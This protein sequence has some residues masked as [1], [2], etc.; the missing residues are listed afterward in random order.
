MKSV[1]L[2]GLCRFG[3][4]MAQ[5]LQE[6]HHEVLAVD[7]EEQR[8]ND[9]LPYVTNAQIGDA[10]NE[11]FIASLGVRNFD[12]CVVAIG[13]DFQSSLEATALLKE[14]G[15][16]FVV[17]RAARDVHAKFLLRNG[18]DDVIY[19]ER[20]MASWAAVRYSSGHIFDYVELTPEY[21]IFET[22]VPESWVGKTVV[23]LE[24]RQKYRINILAIQRGGKLEPL[25]GP[26]HCFQA[27]ETMFILGDNRDMKKFLRLS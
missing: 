17:S 8:V 12:L 9:A 2:I 14:N 10:T 16:P 15:A 26:G 20:Q 13:D 6:L 23:D 3:R 24:V 21:S 27:H 11:A 25:P 4:H 19:P 1:L 5:K 22:A 18:A 7:K